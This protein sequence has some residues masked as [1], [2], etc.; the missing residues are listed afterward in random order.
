MTQQEKPLLSIE[1]LSI[2]FDTDKGPIHALRGISF[3]IHKGEFLGIV[4]ESGSGKSVTS[5]HLMSLLPE[6]AVMETGTITQ[7]PGTRAAMIFQYP[8]TALN[9]IRRVGDQII[10]VLDAVD[11]RNFPQGKDPEKKGM[12]KKDQKERYRKEAISWLETVKIKNP[13]DNIDAFPFEL[14]GG[15]CQRIL[16]A[17]ALAQN[18]SLLIADEP[19]TALDVVTQKTILEL[20]LELKAQRGLTVL[21]ITHDLALAYK[22][23]SRILVMEKGLIVEKGSP[24]GIIKGSLKTPITP[25]PRA[26]YPLLRFL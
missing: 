8:R 6:Y 26:W 7:E 4:G 10:D 2:R 24:E 13:Q 14:S 25:T 12:S 5:L 17:M 18:P 9:P 16:I 11:K 21:F 20:I 1:D 19:T 15:M 23:C 3:D 22:Y